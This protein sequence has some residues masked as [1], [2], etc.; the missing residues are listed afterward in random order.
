MNYKIAPLIAA[1]ILSGFA[2]TASAQPDGFH[3]GTFIEEFGP[4][5]TI[6]DRDPIPE[7]ATFKVSFDLADRAEPG[8][9][10]RQL[11]SAA[12][13][14]NMHA[15]AGVPAEN[16]SLAMVIHGSA[17]QD[18]TNENAYGAANGQANANATLVGELLK[19]G[20]EIHVCG[21]SAAYQGLT[22]VDLL[23][24]VRMSLSAMT[25]HAL[26]QQEGYTLNPF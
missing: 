23:P 1:M 8:T 26:L 15:E 5:A 14:L 13:F 9:L 24:G 21:Q 18:V 7:D 22:K 6:N 16:M 19:H 25:A 12:R 4:V 20:V 3:P 2:M 17:V 10:N 11:V